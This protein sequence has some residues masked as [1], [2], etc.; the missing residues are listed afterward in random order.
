MRKNITV[1]ARMQDDGKVIP[2]T[3]LWNNEKSFEIDK[4]LDIRKKASTKG[5]GKG[6]RYTCK[7]LEQERFLWLD[8]NIWFVEV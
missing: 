8:D 1:I 6:L 3:I 5:G 7:I 2:L 4:V